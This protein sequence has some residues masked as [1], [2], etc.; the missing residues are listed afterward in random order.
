MAKQKQIVLQHLERVLVEPERFA[1]L[2]LLFPLVSEQHA[3]VQTV[4]QQTEQLDDT[5]RATERTVA[6]LKERR[7]A[8]ISAAVTDRIA[9]R[10]ET[11]GEPVGLPIDVHRQPSGPREIGR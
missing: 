2:Q 1:T 6:L 3:I 9:I 8:L 10:C 4:S 7:S 11:S 5:S